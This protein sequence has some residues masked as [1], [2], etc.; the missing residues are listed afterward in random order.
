M[1]MNGL[2][3]LVASV[4]PGLTANGDECGINFIFCD[5]VRFRLTM[6]NA[7]AMKLIELLSAHIY[8]VGNSTDSATDLR[9]YP[10]LD[11]I[12]KALG[13]VRDQLSKVTIDSANTNLI[14]AA[15][16]GIV[17]AVEMTNQVFP[18]GGR[19]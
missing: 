11:D 19:P 2:S 17:K 7:E 12:K 9:K 8:D 5:A 18:E 6:T 14:R 15:M 3:G 4:Q 13:T 16:F 1:K 10:N